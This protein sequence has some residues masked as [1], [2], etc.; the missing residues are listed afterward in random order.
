LIDE[1]K[2]NA[3]TG[4]IYTRGNVDIIEGVGEVGAD[5]YWVKALDDRLGVITAT[6]RAPAD[7][8]KKP[9]GGK[10]KKTIG[11]NLSEGEALFKE[12]QLSL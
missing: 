4:S 8:Q 1:K 11:K 6:N 9:T 7:R 10:K 3:K 2:K 5:F 12:F